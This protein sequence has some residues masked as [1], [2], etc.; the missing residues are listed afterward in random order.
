MKRSAPHDTQPTRTITADTETVSTLARRRSLRLTPSL[1]C[2]LVGVVALI[3][4]IGAIGWLA[5]RPRPVTITIDG[6]RYSGDTRA[7]TVAQLLTEQGI[8]LRAEDRV[9]P[10]PTASLP[11]DGQVVIR[12]ARPILLTVDGADAIAWAAEAD[13]PALLTA[14]GIRLSAADRLWIDGQ[15]AP[16]DDAAAWPEA[17]DQIVIRRAV[18]FTVEVD[19]VRLTI[20]SAEPTIAS[21]LYAAGIRLHAA[22]RITV[23]GQRARLNTPPRAGAF[24][25]VERAAPV[26]IEVDGRTISTRTGGAAVADVLAE[27]GIALAGLDYTVPSEAAPITP[28]MTVRVFRV[29]EVV[30]AEDS[31]IPYE[32]IVQADA[33]LELD[34]RAVIQAGRPGVQRTTVRIRYENGVEVA[35]TVESSYPAVAA[36]DEIVAYGT[37]VVIRTLDTPNGPVEYWRTF[38]VYAT[39]YHPAALGGDNITATGRILQHGIIGADRDLLPFGTEIYV[40]GYGRGVIADTGP[41]R[42]STRWIDLGYSD[43]DWV[44]WHRWVTIYVLTPVPTSIDYFPPP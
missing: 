24:V 4:L 21:A 18:P 12:R 6:T 22:D 37:R 33:D 8:V 38:R 26:Q 3:A 41:D 5:L 10:P 30:I 28:G 15:P 36:Q 16:A 35:R 29:K 40:E 19:G 44:N 43:E 23:D 1:G 13:L 7:S 17:F 31:P 14:H 20:A 34:Q 11:D 42:D 9:L 2:A 32:T 39:S 25:R 27:A